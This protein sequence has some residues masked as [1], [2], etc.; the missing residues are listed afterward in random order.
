M[1]L[2]TL[3]I[4]LGAAAG[5]TYYASLQGLL[6]VEIAQIITKLPL[7]QLPQN[8]QLSQLQ[9][10]SLS[11]SSSAQ[12]QTLLERSGEVVGHAQQVLGT[13]ITATEGE[14]PLSQRAFEYGRYLYCQQAIKEYESKQDKQE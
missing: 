13:Q 1:K 10:I 12:A 3:L 11:S 9:S 14:Q 5:G 8:V 7:P 2:L 4:I 6:P